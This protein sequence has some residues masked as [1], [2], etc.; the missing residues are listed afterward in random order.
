M[1]VIIFRRIGTQQFLILGYVPFEFDKRGYDEASEHKGA[2]ESV[3]S[4][5]QP[6][7][8]YPISL[9]REHVK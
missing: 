4:L 9:S 7:T 3:V 6:L 2:G 1:K 5:E 8:R